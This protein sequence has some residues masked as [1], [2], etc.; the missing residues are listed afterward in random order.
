[1]NKEEIR[2]KMKEL[3]YSQS[4]E[5]VKYK[6][7]MIMNKLLS[8]KEFMEASSV[9]VYLSKP[10][11]VDTNYTVEHLLGKKR[12]SVPV[13]NSKID[14][15]EFTS[16]NDLVAGKFGILEP[17]TKSFIDYTPDLILIPGVAF[18]IKKN[19]LGYGKGFYDIFLKNKSITKIALAFDFQIVEKLPNEKHDIP[20]DLII[21]EKRII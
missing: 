2:S 4:R 15:V 17:K 7:E 10:H 14:L 3:L 12:L 19:R 13:T 20:M 9:S 21:T 6:S 8:I 5:D 18:D 16:F 1:M 11:E